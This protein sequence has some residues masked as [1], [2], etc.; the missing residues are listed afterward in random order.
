M[1]EF[2]VYVN[3]RAL[4]EGLS[5]DEYFER[6]R[7]EIRRDWVGQRVIHS[8]AW[9]GDALNRALVDR[10]IVVTLAAGAFQAPQHYFNKSAEKD[11]REISLIWSDW[12]HHERFIVP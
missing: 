8:R 10:L 2:S 9:N 5:Y 4:V 12:T 1:I 3:H 6:L 11:L 7:D